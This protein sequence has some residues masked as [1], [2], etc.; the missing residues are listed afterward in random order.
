MRLLIKAELNLRA[1]RGNSRF[2]LTDRASYSTGNWNT[3]AR[4]RSRPDKAFTDLALNLIVPEVG[5]SKPDRRFSKVVLPAP[6]APS[7]ASVSP[8][9]ILS[10]VEFSAGSTVPGY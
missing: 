4:F 9:S 2:S 5:S 8:S 1:L 6:D 7:M 10:E 3:C